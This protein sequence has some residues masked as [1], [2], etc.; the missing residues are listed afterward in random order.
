MNSLVRV[1]C[2]GDAA[3]RGARRALLLLLLLLL[4]RAAAAIQTLL[5]KRR[6]RRRRSGGDGR[7]RRSTAARP[8]RRSK[9][10][11][12][13]RLHRPGGPASRGDREAHLGT[14]GE[15]KGKESKK[16]IVERA[17]G[18]KKIKTLSTLLRPLLSLPPFAPLRLSSFFAAATAN[19]TKALACSSKAPL[20]E[21]LSLASAT[22]R[23][24]EREKERE[25][26][27]PLFLPFLSRRSTPK[28]KKKRKEKT[29]KKKNGL[30]PPPPSPPRLACEA[31]AVPHGAPL[32]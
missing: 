8:R 3:G 28:E 16:W 6:R 10:V 25:R 2:G 7:R 29:P 31:R 11:P 17:R 14:A 30:S 19:Q 20:F 18:E 23:E 9:V 32:G 15:E 5:A 4:R 22:A 21:L 24:A 1:C 26:A 13:A 27:L 12:A